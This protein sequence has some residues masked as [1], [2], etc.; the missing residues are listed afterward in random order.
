M[1]AKRA[2]EERAGSPY[3][4]AFFE[5]RIL[6]RPRASGAQGH[7]VC[8]GFFHAKTCSHRPPTSDLRL[9][10]IPP[11][12]ECTSVRSGRDSTPCPHTAAAR[13]CTTT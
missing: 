12:R 13:T 1:N 10:I 7:L 3:G 9:T 5:S 11:S 6:A 2:A 8:G 4:Y